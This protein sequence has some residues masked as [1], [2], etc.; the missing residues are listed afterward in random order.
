MSTT[1]TRR[2]ATRPSGAHV[3][4][5]RPAPHAIGDAFLTLLAIGGL[6][7]VALVVMS[8]AFQITLIMFKTGSMSPTIPAGSVAVVRQIPADEIDVGDVVTVDRPGDL[9]VTHRVTS[10]A[11]VE[12]SPDART[13]TMQGDANASP[14]P[15]PYT[16]DTV[17]VVIA[18][19]PYL[20]SVIVWFSNPVVLGAVTLAASALVVWAFWPRRDEVREGDD[21]VASPAG[22]A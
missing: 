10:L 14:D 15:L 13:I 7:C 2:R 5:R 20:A 22:G 6:V 17:R 21:S 4:P 8:V 19:V 9:P 1:T 16:V 3:R 12:G 18:S 11:V